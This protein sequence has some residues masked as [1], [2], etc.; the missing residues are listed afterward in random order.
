MYQMPYSNNADLHNVDPQ[1]Q[2]NNSPSPSDPRNGA[3]WPTQQLGPMP[4]AP[5]RKRL[6]GLIIAGIALTVI[7]LLTTVIAGVSNLSRHSSTTHAAATAVST[8]PWHAT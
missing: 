3:Y 2:E 1:A 8:Q 7:V 6:R 5:S 4:P